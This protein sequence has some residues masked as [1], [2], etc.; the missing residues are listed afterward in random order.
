MPPVVLRRASR[1]RSV[2]LR[3]PRV[4]LPE[5]LVVPDEGDVVRG[6]SGVG[7]EGGGEL[8]ETGLEGGES[9]LGAKAAASAMT[10]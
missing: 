9:V 6:D 1:N 4:P 8:V 10:N 3:Y 2:L 7:L 5:E